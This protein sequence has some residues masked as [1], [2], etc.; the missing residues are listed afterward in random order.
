V[1]L[2][3][4]KVTFLL[5]GQ[6]DYGIALRY[7][8]IGGVGWLITQA[9]RGVYQAEEKFVSYIRTLWLRQLLLFIII[10]PLFLLKHLDY[11]RTFYATIIAEL[12][13][14]SIVVFHIFHDVRIGKVVLFFKEQFGV[15][16]EFISSTGWLIA[17][18]FTLGSF[19][20]FDIFMLS[21]MTAENE[22]ANYGVA[23]RY[24]SMALMVL[25]S[26]HA[27]LLPR[28]SKVDMQDI[29]RQ[30]QFTYKWMKIAV[31]II[32]P[33]LIFDIFGKQLF[34]MVNGAQYEKAFYVFVIFSIGVWLSLMFSP[35]VNI[36]IARKSFKFLFVI[37]LGAFA[38]NFTGNY[39]LI[40]VWGGFG[41][42]IVTIL[43]QNVFLQGLI[44]IKLFRSN[45]NETI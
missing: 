45:R 16:K 4:D 29:N 30:R 33:I 9:G 15:I 28:F 39:F 37:G 10:L 32:I 19:Q 44:L 22:L 21:H 31:W 36:L 34:V 35:L 20:R 24:Y 38:I 1:L 17:Y 25:S 5:F 13:V 18:F 12:T 7:G 40:P 6:K 8:L 43:S 41:A 3:S 23:S 11:E 2:L 14:A 26:I 27:V 42:A